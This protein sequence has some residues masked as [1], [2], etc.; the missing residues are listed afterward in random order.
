MCGIWDFFAAAGV[1]LSP[2]SSLTSAVLAIVVV[3]VY[4]AI[5]NVRD[6][7]DLGRNRL[8]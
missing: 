3:S 8:K 5:A 1:A 2:A 7:G 6:A 4:S